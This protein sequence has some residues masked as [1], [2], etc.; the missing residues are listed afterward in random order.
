MRQG[1]L[2]E[3]APVSKTLTPHFCELFLLGVLSEDNLPSREM[4]PGVTSYAGLRTT[5]LIPPK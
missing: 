4:I 3:T 5:L 1:S 2:R